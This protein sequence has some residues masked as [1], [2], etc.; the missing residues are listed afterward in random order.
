MNTGILHIH[1]AFGLLLVIG[2]WR[3]FATRY[4]MAMG[5][6]ALVLLATGAHNFMTSMKSATPAWHALVGIKLLLALHA[7]AMVFLLA[8]GAADAA[9]AARWRKGALISGTITALIGLYVSN[10]LGR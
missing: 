9:K 10:L 1:L 4:R 6:I 2:L 5:L 3:G 8:R 7:L